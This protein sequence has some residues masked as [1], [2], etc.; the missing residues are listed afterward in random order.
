MQSLEQSIQAVLCIIMHFNNLSISF[1]KD[2]CIEWICCFSLC[3]RLCTE[4]M[5]SITIIEFIHS[6]SC[7]ITCLIILAHLPSFLLNFSHPCSFLA[8][9]SLT[10][11][12]LLTPF[13]INHFHDPFHLFQFNRSI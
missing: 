12:F 9:H 8:H 4:R 13:D 2:G 10:N 3:T 11:H 6:N 7:T 1:F 5:K